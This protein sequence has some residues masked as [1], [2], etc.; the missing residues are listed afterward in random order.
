[1]MDDYSVAH[2]NIVNLNDLNFYKQLNITN[3]IGKAII[4]TR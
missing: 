3:I 1:M 4:Y 2:D